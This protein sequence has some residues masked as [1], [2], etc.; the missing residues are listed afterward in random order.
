[1]AERR[2]VPPGV[3]LHVHRQVF[4]LLLVKGLVVKIPDKTQFLIGV[5]PL[6][7]NDA[8]IVAYRLISDLEHQD[9]VVLDAGLDQILDRDR[10]PYGVV[11][12]IVIADLCPLDQARA[13]DTPDLEGDLAD[14]VP[15]LVHHK[16]EFAPLPERCDRIP[17]KTSVHLLFQP[18]QIVIWDPVC[19]DMHQREGRLLHAGGQLLVSLIVNTAAHKKR[20]DKN[21][22]AGS[23]LT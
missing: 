14:R 23:Q 7:V 22:N 3:G 16:A 10:R 1:M 4:C 19:H 12:V 21:D 5:I 2:I 18:V 20:D 15:V 11:L 9:P 17:E 8:R 6:A 13:V